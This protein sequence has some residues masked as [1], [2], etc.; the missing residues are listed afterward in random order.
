MNEQMTN[1]DSL[2]KW[3]EQYYDAI[4]QCSERYVAMAPDEEDIQNFL[5]EFDRTVPLVKLS[6]WL[7]YVQGV[8]IER[9]FTTVQEERDWTRGLFRPL[10]FDRSQIA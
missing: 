7:G 6:R 2:V 4:E 10:D 5:V 8:L 3:T 9:G 1:N